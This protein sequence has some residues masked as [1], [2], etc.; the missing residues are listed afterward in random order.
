MPRT[1]N[2]IQR[3]WGYLAAVGGVILVTSLLA[4]IVADLNPT[5]VALALLL[6]VL[7]VATLFGSRPA[8]VASFLGVLSFNFFFLP[9]LHTFTIADP[10]N[11][12][13]FAAFL[14][15]A[16]IAGQ[17]SSYAQ[18]RAIES[19]SHRREIERLYAE[20]KAAFE[21]AS[22]A[23]AYRQGEQLK[24]SLLDA[25]THDLRTPLTSIK[26]SVTTLI[27]GSAE[28]TAKGERQ[29]EL[30][31]ESHDQLLYLINEETDRLNDFIGGI[32]ELARIQA[33][34]TNSRKSW[35]DVI[36]IIDAALDRARTRLSDHKIILSI[37]RDLPIARVN[38]D[39]VGEVVYTFL[40]NASKYSPPRSAIRISASR[41]E[42][43]TMI[44]SVEDKGHGIDPEKREM[45][46]EKF[47]RV[48]KN[49]IHT[50]GSSLGIG[51]AIARGIAESQ[52]GSVWVEDGK[53]GFSTR[54]VFQFP[55]GD[56]EA[57][58]T[59]GGEV[60]ASDAI[61]SEG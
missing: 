6:D 34:E 61:G 10:Q 7:V 15:T 35:F 18:R 45:V 38:A 2:L 23:E 59:A 33:G 11:W 21:Q 1:W 31:K 28:R 3:R 54:F 36:E 57:V 51:L 19:E 56:D 29:M 27:E 25:V 53:D 55:T 8:L 52:G 60:S 50:T 48:S 42:D 22:H 49:D 16:I 13:A 12:F 24:S 9:P 58:V 40:D 37:E 20:L 41:G 39:A 5:I 43:E 14:V 30:S 4:P 47:Y 46:F 32:V 44:V 26:A 17:L